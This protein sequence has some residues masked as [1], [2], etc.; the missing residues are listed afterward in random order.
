[1]ASWSRFCPNSGEPHF[2]SSLSCPSCKAINPEYH[3]TETI[4][5]T[6][7]EP[8]ALFVQSQHSKPLKTYSRKPQIPTIEHLRQ[9]SLGRQPV[10]RASAP[11]Q[12]M[13]L[14][15]V[16]VKFYL[17][18]VKVPWDDDQPLEQPTMVFLGES[19]L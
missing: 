15:R 6:D 1:M 3:R 13:T 19:R 11:S 7:D 9:T 17:Q 8:G 12:S 16:L 18:E 14:Y 5:L 2:K 4:D 10:R